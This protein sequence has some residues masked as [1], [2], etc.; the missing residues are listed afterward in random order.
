MFPTHSLSSWWVNVHILLAI[1]P[2]VV[3][4]CMH[5]YQLHYYL[6]YAG[7][8]VCCV[9]VSFTCYAHYLGIQITAEKKT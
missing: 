7:R 9:L 1:T 5:V 8:Y 3:E 2:S 4:V 6:I